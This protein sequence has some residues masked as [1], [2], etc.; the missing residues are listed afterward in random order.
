MIDSWLEEIGELL[1]IGLTLYRLRL[2][3]LMA[4]VE[5]P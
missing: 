5:A 1:M 3:T 2:L 4:V